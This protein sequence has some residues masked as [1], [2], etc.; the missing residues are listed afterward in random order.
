MQTNHPYNCVTSL[1]CGNAIRQN[2]RSSYTQYRDLAFRFEHLVGEMRWD[3][4]FV[5]YFW[6]FDL[7]GDRGIM[8]KFWRFIV[9]LGGLRKCDSFIKTRIRQLILYRIKKSRIHIP[10]AHQMKRELERRSGGRWA[11]A[12]TRILGASRRHPYSPRIDFIRTA[13]TLWTISDR[14]FTLRR[15]S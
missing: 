2:P 10:L 5:L 6:G 14:V 13:H 11:R 8:R 7:Y 12:G 1:W 4:R 9:Q 3:I 15:P